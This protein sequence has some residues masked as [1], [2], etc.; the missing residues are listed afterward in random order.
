MGFELRLK[1]MMRFQNLK[2][3]E[4]RVFSEKRSLLKYGCRTRI[5]NTDDVCGSGSHRFA[6]EI[7]GH[8]LFFGKALLEAAYTIS[9]FS[10]CKMPVT[11]LSIQSLV[12]SSLSESG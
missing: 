4:G 7:K 12:E 9:S 11:F 1:E 6:V 5:V 10:S 8:D 3:G 2:I